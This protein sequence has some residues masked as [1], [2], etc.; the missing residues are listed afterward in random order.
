MRELIFEVVEDPEC[1]LRAD[2]LGAP[3][4][5]FGKDI[6][7]LRTHVQEA[8]DAYHCGPEGPRPAVVR[9]HAS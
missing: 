8:V 7:E 4:H 9:L 6:A 3:I 2:A 1:G 5:T